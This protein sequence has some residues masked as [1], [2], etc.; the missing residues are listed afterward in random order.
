MLISEEYRLIKRTGKNNT[1]V[2]Y[3][4]YDQM[5]KPTFLSVDALT[6]EARDFFDDGDG[7]VT[8]V[9]PFAE[10]EK[11]NEHEPN[12]LI[13]YEHGRNVNGSPNDAIT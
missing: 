6:S 5:R 8:G 3:V 10:M 9:G 2:C 13:Y 7:K 11:I 12:C 1:A 4:L